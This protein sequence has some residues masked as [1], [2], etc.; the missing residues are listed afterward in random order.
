MTP[1]DQAKNRARTANTALRRLGIRPNTRPTRL[2][3]A[4]HCQIDPCCCSRTWVYPA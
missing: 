3:H 4:P 2:G 1:D